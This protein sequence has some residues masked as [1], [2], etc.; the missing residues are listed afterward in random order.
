MYRFSYH[1][2]GTSWNIALWDDLDETV[3]KNIEQEVIAATSAFEA[4]YSRFKTDSLIWELSRQTGYVEVPTPLVEMLRLYQ[5]FFEL[6]G[7]KFTPLIAENLRQAGYDEHYRLTAE[8]AFTEVPALPDVVQIEDDTHITLHKAALLDLGGL[9]K[10]YFVDEIAHLL[11]HR[12]VQRF[13]VDGSGDLYYHGPGAVRIGL[14]HPKDPTQAVGTVDLTQGALCGSGS[15]HRKWAN[16]HHIV[17]PQTH[18]SPQTILASWV[19]A[20]RAV[21]ADGLATCLFLCEPTQLQGAWP[22]SYCLVAPDLSAQFSPGFGGQ[23]FT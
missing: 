17:D 20:E 18:T 7:G 1:A 4:V 22:F 3:A 8:G 10:G 9:G 6:T 19:R 13:L 5:R 2:M 23:L 16:F 14:Q 11:K 21:L 15:Y 12:G